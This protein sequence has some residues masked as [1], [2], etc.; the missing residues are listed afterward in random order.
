VTA[1]RDAGLTLT[2]SEEDAERFFALGFVLEQMRGNFEDLRAR[3]TDWARVE[4]A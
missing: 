4:P 3:V 1:L 2:L